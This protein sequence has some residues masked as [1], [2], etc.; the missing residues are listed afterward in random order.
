MSLT[1]DPHNTS[2]GG[3]GGVSE[4][5]AS[6][7]I[8]SPPRAKGAQTS[9]DT[10]ASPDTL[11]PSSSSARPSK[12]KRPTAAPATPA[13]AP[14][15]AA[16]GFNAAK[17]AESTKRRRVAHRRTD[18][19]QP[20]F[21]RLLKRHADNNRIFVRGVAVS[22]TKAGV[23]AAFARDVLC[24]V[25]RAT[26]AAAGDA[27]AQEHALA[28]LRGV[29]FPRV[30]PELLRRDQQRP[31]KVFIYAF[32]ELRAGRYAVGAAAG[33]ATGATVSSEEL[34]ALVAK[35]DR[36]AN[37]EAGKLSL[38]QYRMPFSQ[39]P[40]PPA[41]A[42]EVEE[43]GSGG[44]G[45]TLRVSGLSA[46]VDTSEDELRLVL[47]NLEPAPRTVR[48]AEGRASALLRF[49]SAAQAMAAHRTLDGSGYSEAAA[50]GR[51]D[52]LAESAVLRCE[53]VS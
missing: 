2:G 19:Q 32:V 6:F 7:S 42:Q 25:L 27:A 43:E 26:A 16:A 49:D 39:V 20:A 22:A 34:A 13:A 28:A 8:F 1:E 53:I 44:G 48:V 37:G 17:A 50:F 35:R 23:A 24:P 46:L 14:Q 21:V 5:D 3:G 38:P 45:R 4:D 52:A 30:S 36:A 10:S 33:D 40:A 15:P 41:G 31:G 11:P 18:L 12:R 29:T 9:A 47:S 51:C